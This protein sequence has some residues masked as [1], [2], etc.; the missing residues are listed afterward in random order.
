[1][2]MLLSW[3]TWWHS[4]QASEQ[5]FWSIGLISTLLFII[6]LLMQ[7]LGHDADVDADMDMN[8]GDIGF[9]LL[10]FRSLIAFTMFMGYAGALSLGMGWGLLPAVLFGIAA[11]SPAGR[12][13]Y[14]LG[15][16]LLKQQS[17]G[18]L[19]IYNAIG[20]KGQVHLYIPAEAKAN[21]K[22]MITIQGALRELDAI[23]YGPAIPTGTPVIVESV[24]DDNLLVVTTSH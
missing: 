8:G 3:T 24:S 14:L 21:G 23:T 7:L 18:T 4:L 13:S 15:R 19:D 11:G 5:I 10:S 6:Y 12:V 1:M 17:S 20:Q 2:V 22:I 16:F 9:A